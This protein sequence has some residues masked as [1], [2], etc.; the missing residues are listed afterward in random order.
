MKRLVV[1]FGYPVNEKWRWA[2]YKHTQIPHLGRLKG[3][4]YDFIEVGGGRGIVNAT[5]KD[6]GPSWRMIVQLG[7]RIQ[8]F[9]IYPGG[10]SGNPGSPYY[11]NM[12]IKWAEG[13]WDTLLFPVS[14][15]DFQKK[16]DA[17]LK[18]YVEP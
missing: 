2:G 11:D 18:W 4:G 13:K 5:G 3:F 17:L 1:M 6:H 8:G 15:S 10:Q 9:G 12:V 16:E 7:P 14:E